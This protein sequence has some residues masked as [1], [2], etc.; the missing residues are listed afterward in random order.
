[1]FVDAPY[2]YIYIYRFPKIFSGICKACL[3]RIL[4]P[5]NKPSFVPRFAL[6]LWIRVLIRAKFA[7][8]EFGYTMPQLLSYHGLGQVTT[9][10]TMSPE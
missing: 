1:M 8:T 2:I 4:N 5:L 9:Q 10:P 6:Q 3:G 7:L